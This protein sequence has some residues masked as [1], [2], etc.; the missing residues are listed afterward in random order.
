[1]PNSNS[2]SE[3]DCQ[4]DVSLLKMRRE[5]LGSGGKPSVCSVWL[6]VVLLFCCVFYSLTVLHTG[7]TSF[8]SVY[9]YFPLADANGREVFDKR[10]GNRASCRLLGHGGCGG[11][12][13][14][15]RHEQVSPPVNICWGLFSLPSSLSKHTKIEKEWLFFNQTIQDAANLRW[16]PPFQADKTYIYHSYNADERNERL[17]KKKKS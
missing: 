12:M 10:E 7:N 8:T 2:I 6:L 5:I 4:H 3:V 17:K 1:M 9:T 15:L 13:C 14:W 11:G 16:F